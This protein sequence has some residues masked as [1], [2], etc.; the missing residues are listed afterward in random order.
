VQARLHE[1]EQKGLEQAA[2]AQR[3]LLRAQPFWD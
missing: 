1:E 3:R 2:A